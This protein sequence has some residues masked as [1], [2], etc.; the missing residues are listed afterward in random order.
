MTDETSEDFAQAVAQAEIA[1]HT[2][3][4]TE[5]Y[6]RRGRRYHALSDEQLTGLWVSVIRIWAK[7]FHLRPTEV[8]DAE[9]EFSLRGVVPSGALVKAE[10]DQIC[11]AAANMIERLPEEA[12]D[13]LNNEIEAAYLEDLQWKN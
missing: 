1:R 7:A 12:K 2:L 9:A 5:D 10:L 8:A 4:R 13:R 11:A 3:A 6:L